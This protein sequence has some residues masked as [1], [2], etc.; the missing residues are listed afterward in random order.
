MLRLLAL[1]VFAAGSGNAFAQDWG[2][3]AVISSSMGV[4]ASR[5]CLGEASRGDIG[6]PAYAPSVTTAGDLTVS[7][8]MT[9]NKFIGDGSGLTGVTAGS[10][11]RI[12]SGSTN[13]TSLIAISATG[14]ISATQNGTNTAYFHPTLGLVTIGVSSTGPISGTAGY[15]SGNVGIGTTNPVSKLHVSAGNI[16][17]TNSDLVIGTTGSVL[18]E[19][20]GA[21]SGNTYSAFQAYTAGA[22]ALGNLVL[23]GAG[24][25]VGIGTVTPTANLEVLGNISASNVYV[26]ASIGTVSATYG[27]FTY[28]SASNGLSTAAGDRIVSGSTSVVGNSTTSIISITN[29]GVTSG[30]FN[31]NG[32]LT[33]P[34]ISATVNL[35]SVTTLYAGS[36]VT[37]GIPSTTFPFMLQG[38][39]AGNLVASIVNTNATNGAASLLMLG[40]NTSSNAAGTLFENGSASTGWS[41][42]NGLNLIN[43]L[44]APVGIGAAGVIAILISPSGNVGIGTLSPTSKLEVSGTVSATNVYVTSTTGKV[45][46]TYGYFNFISGTQISG[47]FIGDGSGSADRIV[48]GSTSMVANSTTSI[49][50]ITTAGTITGYFNSNGVLTVPG[51]SATANLT[52]ITSLYASGNVGIGT[53]SPGVKLTVKQGASGDPSQGIQLTDG[54]NFREIYLTA[55]DSTMSFNNGINTANLTSAGVWSNASDIHIKKNIVNMSRYGLATVMRMRP[56]EY[57]MKVNSEP[58]VG[59]IAQ[60]MKKVVP[61]V[62]SGQD[63]SMSLSY[64][65]LVAV[66]VKAIQ[67]LKADNDN[68]RAEFEAYKRA[69]P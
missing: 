31:S 14:I 50:S 4:S 1:L 30:Y 53:T 15:F 16:N 3:L 34:G 51:I 54:T 12:V 59:F 43:F 57:Q 37:I 13:Q 5:L 47:K 55:N 65:N 67:E 25:N 27:Y 40:N 9:A 8:T 56:V 19:Y 66:T 61:E 21:T 23:N 35:T 29:A 63:G 39:V 60:E 44:S 45:S 41:G 64:G 32:V 69:H 52:S 7:G 46:G 11:D 49:I 20:L 18:T 38:N 24:G 62:V 2:K 68:L 26:T 17:L 22:N 10:A 6:C 42:S 33:V 36:N 28:I 48:S 58:Q